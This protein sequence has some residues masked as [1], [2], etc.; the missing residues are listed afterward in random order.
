MSIHIGEQY[1][2]YFLFT[3]EGSNRAFII[4]P[5]E[6]PL[7]YENELFCCNVN[8]KFLFFNVGEER[9]MTIRFESNPTINQNNANSNDIKFRIKF[10]SWDDVEILK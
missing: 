1:G 9:E 5:L 10:N 2:L 4:T 3:Y 7:W 8:G 6:T